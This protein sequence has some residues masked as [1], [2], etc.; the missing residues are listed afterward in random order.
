MCVFI[1]RSI[2]NAKT[3]YYTLFI[4]RIV[5]SLDTCAFVDNSPCVYFLILPT[6]VIKTQK[7]SSDLKVVQLQTL[8]L[9][10]VFQKTQ[11]GSQSKGNLGYHLR[12]SITENT[13]VWEF[14]F[15]WWYKYHAG[16]QQHW[17]TRGS[18]HDPSTLGTM[19]DTTEK[20]VS[21]VPHRLT[22]HIARSVSH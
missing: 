10:H 7:C 20:D 13:A 18:I 17:L 6:A 12:D 11:W 16:G 5:T 14:E 1:V 8:M 2:W 22:S 9:K 3:L 19:W 21:L 4:Q 15:F